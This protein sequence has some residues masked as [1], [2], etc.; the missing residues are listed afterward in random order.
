[1]ASIFKKEFYMQ[2]PFTTLKNL[3]LHAKKRQKN[4]I[5]KSLRSPHRI[6]CARRRS[7]PALQHLTSSQNHR[8]NP[9][10]QPPV[11]IY[12]KCGERKIDRVSIIHYSTSS[13]LSAACQRS[14]AAARMNREVPL[15]HHP[16]LTFFCTRNEWK[17]LYYKIQKLS[18]CV[19]VGGGCTF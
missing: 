6:C 9:L 1:M 7:S 16:A 11:F 5:R 13:L 15:P 3:C 4:V 18:M 17:N 2:Q 14:P 12:K 8:Q 19:C 10:Q